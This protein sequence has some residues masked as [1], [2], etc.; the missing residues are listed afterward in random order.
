MKT[1]C[2]GVIHFEATD[3]L[4]ALKELLS[5]V[6]IEEI[7]VGRDHGC[8]CGCGGNYYNFDQ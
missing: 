5:N 4:P 2:D 1:D 7:Y 3:V 8:R 6:K